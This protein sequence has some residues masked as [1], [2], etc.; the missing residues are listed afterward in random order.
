M[1][2]IYRDIHSTGTDHML[3]V[4]DF[5]SSWDNRRFLA[6]LHEGLTDGAAARGD[7]LAMTWPNDAIV[8]PLVRIDHVLTGAH[9]AV[10]SIRTKAGYGSDH[11]YLLATVAVQ[12]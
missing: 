11:R 3:V 8:P 7:A 6:I 2:G 1:V 4:G 9:V 5:N 10:T 12:S